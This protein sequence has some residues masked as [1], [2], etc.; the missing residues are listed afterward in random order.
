MVGHVEASMNTDPTIK[1]TRI[2][3]REGHIVP[4]D[5]EKITSA[6][7][8]AIAATGSRDHALAESL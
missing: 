1:I 4:F 7:Y 5:K 6:I 3:K 2:R 8:R